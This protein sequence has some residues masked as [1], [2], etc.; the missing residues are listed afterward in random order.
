[1]KKSVLV[2]TS[3]VLAAAQ[4]GTTEPPCALVASMLAR[5]S[6]TVVPAIEAFN[7]LDSVPVDIQ[8]NSRLIDELKEAW[9]FHSETVWLKNPGSDWEYGPLDIMGELDEVKSNLGSYSSEYAVQLAIQ[10]ITIRTGNFHFNYQPDILQVF[11][12]R[13]GFNVASISSDGKAL[14]KLYVHDDVAALADGDDSVSDI[15]SINGMAPYDFLKANF[16]SQYIDSDGRMNRMFAKGD[17][18]HP[19]AFDRQAKY[20]GNS[21]DIVWTN[22]SQASFWNIATSQQSFKGV[23]DGET[24]FE[25]F[26]AGELTGLKSSA[27]NGKENKVISPGLLGPVP[28]IP[29]GTYHLSSRTKRQAIP[30]TSSYARAVAAAKARTVAGYFLTES[31][32]S[33]VA[34]LKIISFSNPDDE[35]FDDISFNSDFQATVQAFLEQC[36]SQKKQKLIIDLRENGGG[37][38]DLL[39]DTFM[40]LFPDMEPFSA[41]RY[42]A[43]DAFN[44]M[45]D[46][47]NEVYTNSNLAS[48]FRTAFSQTIQDGEAFRYW[49]WWHFRT[50]EGKNFDGWDQFNGPLEMNNDK[51]T[52]TFRY[53]YS[54]SDRVSILSSGFNFVGGSRPTAFQPSNVVMFTDALCGSSCASFHEELKNIAG[55]KAVT[56]GGRPENK[57]IQTVAGTKGGEVIPLIRFAQLA[58]EMLNFSSAAGLSSV[59]SDDV[60]LNAVADVPNV[61]VRVGDDSSRLQ[62]QDQIRKGD[63]TATPLQY[64]Y[65]A[66]DCRIFYTAESY[67]DPVEAWKQVWSA[68]SDNSKCVE[69]STGHKSSI[70]GGYKPFGSAQVTSED[71]P[72]GSG[73]GSEENYSS[74]FKQGSPGMALL[75]V[76]FA[77]VVQMV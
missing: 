7:C 12:F 24:F 49:A 44:K 6:A 47:I 14:P 17:T 15:E 63:K 33:D 11:R 38:V 20:D 57:P 40:Q 41:Q 46:A 55:V 60:V 28:T 68:Y 58:T 59:Q 21:T 18:E 8:G 13:R 56:V 52:T 26:C 54:N 77:L 31:G 67:A 22:S 39:L 50:A 61:A 29:T 9:Q 73:S 34:V 42:R 32:F 16:Y 10:S 27:S 45:G 48:R 76:A 66:A 35:V 25:A 64:I 74:P 1:M 75:A 23:V 69:G 65:E 72:S 71:E 30:S 36:I 2:L 53:N 4:T 3:A 43:T 70:S 62:S 19:G 51:F 5:P 37:S